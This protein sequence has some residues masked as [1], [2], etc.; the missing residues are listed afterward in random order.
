MER[1]LLL[2]SAGAGKSE[3]IAKEALKRAAHGGKVLLLSYTINNQFELVRAICRVNK[4]QPENVVVK[5]WFSFLLEDM[6]RR[7]DAQSPTGRMGNA[8]DIAHAALFLA[9]DEARYVNGVALPVDGGLSLR[10]A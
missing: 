3:R 9:S 2:A 10:F 8:W 4:F 6:I 5:G 7:R 1:K